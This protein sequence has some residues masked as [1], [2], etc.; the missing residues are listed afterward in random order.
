MSYKYDNP[1]DAKPNAKL[2]TATKNPG[3]TQS[4]RL[5]M[6]DEGAFGVSS[7]ITFL[8]NGRRKHDVLTIGRD[9]ARSGAAIGAIRLRL[10]DLLDAAILLAESEL[11]A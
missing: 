7:N 2:E 4:P 10:D 9:D 1:I 8:S 11:L 5:S 3:I 6:F